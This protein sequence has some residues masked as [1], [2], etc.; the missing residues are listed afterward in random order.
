LIGTTT[1]NYDARTAKGGKEKGP[2]G[3]QPSATGPRV[4]FTDERMR[5]ALAGRPVSGLA[6]VDRGD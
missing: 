2:R 1:E 5:Y 6:G 3:R 4:A